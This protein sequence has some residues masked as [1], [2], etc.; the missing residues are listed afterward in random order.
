MRH[1]RHGDPLKLVLWKKWAKSGRLV[2]RDGETAQHQTLWLDLA[3][4]GGANG[5]MEHQLARLCAWVIQAER[6]ALDYGLRLP[7]L[8]LAPDH[9]SAHYHACLEALALH[10]T[11]H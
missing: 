6:L 10:R 7:G 9:G 4:C 5:N 1:Y 3:Q 2:S 8:E 11:P